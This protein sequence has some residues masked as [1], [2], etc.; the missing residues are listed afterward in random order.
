MHPFGDRTA[1]LQPR[2]LDPK[3]RFVINH[4]VF[5]GIEKFIHE[6]LYS[7][8][9]IQGVMKD[10]SDGW[11]SVTHLGLRAALYKSEKHRIYF[12]IGPT[13]IVRE[14]WTRF[15]DAYEGSGFFNETDHPRFGALQHKFI[16]YAFE[17]EY[18][19][20]FNAKNQISLS[21][22]PGIPLATI[23]SVGWKHWWH[24]KEF[25]QVKIYVPKDKKEKKEIRL[26]LLRNRNR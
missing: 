15:G 24:P 26:P 1:H 20:A 2:R 18:D 3:A 21:M 17:F 5:V 4:G 8:K 7:V 23:I 25:R 11:T 16:P 6:D 19:Y 12:G 22:T 10:C 13:M 14:S 9:G